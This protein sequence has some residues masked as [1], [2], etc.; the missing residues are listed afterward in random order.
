M[1]QQRHREI[2][3]NRV[4]GVFR[5]TVG[6]FGLTDYNKVFATLEGEDIFELREVSRDGA[7]VVVRPDHYVSAVLPLED[8]AAL[9]AF[10]AA[11]MLEPATSPDGPRRPVKE[12]V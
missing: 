7:V 2:D 8:T 12:G 6:P 5:P 10:F 1:Y 3:I 4:P 11:V 9:A